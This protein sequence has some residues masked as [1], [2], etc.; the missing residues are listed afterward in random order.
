[1]ANVSELV[2]DGLVKLFFAFF[3]FSVS[4]VLTVLSFLFG[5]VWYYFACGTL[6]TAASVYILKIALSLK[7]IR[8]NIQLGEDNGKTESSDLGDEDSVLQACLFY[9]NGASFTEIQKALNLPHPET[10][11]RLLRKGIGILLQNYKEMKKDE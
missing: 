7:W 8:D 9:R 4:M 5:S 6:W 11:R 3:V 10:A 2:F 1:M